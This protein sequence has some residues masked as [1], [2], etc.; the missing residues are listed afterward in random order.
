M[1]STKCFSPLL[2]AGV[3]RLNDEI[4]EYSKGLWLYATFTCI[5]SVYNNINFEQQ[6]DIFFNLI[7]SWLCNG[8]IKFCPPNDI[9]HEGMEYWNETPN[10]IVDYLRIRFPNEANSENDL[11]VNN[12]FYDIVP[13]VLWKES[14]GDYIGS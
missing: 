12:Y 11:T 13:A 4:L 1:K 2:T 7:Y 3:K 8:I 10:N 9:W 14:N 5:S 6:K